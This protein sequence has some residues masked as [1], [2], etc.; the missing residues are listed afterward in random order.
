MRQKPIKPR[1]RSMGV[2]VG[3]FD[4]ETGQLQ[5][6]EATFRPEVL[7]APLE[8]KK[9]HVHSGLPKHLHA[10]SRRAS[11]CSLPFPVHK[12]A[13]LIGR[14]A[15]SSRLREAVP[16]IWRPPRSSFMPPYRSMCLGKDMSDVEGADTFVG[17]QR[18][19]KRGF[20]WLSSR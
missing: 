4:S 18:R 16:A 17:R 19:R 12:L 5:E 13:R 9:A 7:S 2:L 8:V 6:V 1:R 15:G 20:R 14:A 10:R 11:A 3:T